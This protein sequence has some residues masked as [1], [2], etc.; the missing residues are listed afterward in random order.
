MRPAREGKKERNDRVKVVD[1]NAERVRVKLRIQDKHKRDGEDRSYRVLDVHVPR[2]VSYTHL[3][4]PT[5]R[6]V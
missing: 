5:K 3:T 1:D 2:A 4:L 6:I